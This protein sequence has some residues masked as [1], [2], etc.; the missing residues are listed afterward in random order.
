MLKCLIQQ[1]KPFLDNTDRLKTIVDYNRIVVMRDGLLAEFDTPKNLM[2]NEKSI[3][4]SMAKDD[5]INI[6]DIVE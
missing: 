6:A 1:F 5:G 3:F 2:R 4:Y